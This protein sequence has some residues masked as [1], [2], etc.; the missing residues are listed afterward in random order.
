[1]GKT[2]T[3]VVNNQQTEMLDRLVAEGLGATHGEVIALGFRRFCEEHPELVAA[4]AD[5]G[6]DAS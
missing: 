4:R 1:M 2:V 6:E 3:V 5:A